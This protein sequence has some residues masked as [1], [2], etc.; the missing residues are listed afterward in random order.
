MLFMLR[1]KLRLNLLDAQG[2]IMKLRHDLEHLG[3]VVA[4]FENQPPL[5]DRIRQLEAKLASPPV[6]SLERIRALEERVCDLNAE[7]EADSKVLHDRIYAL[8]ERLMRLED[9]DAGKKISTSFADAV[10]EANPMEEP[11]AFAFARSG[12]FTSAG[13]V[14]PRA[15]HVTLE[16]PEGYHLLG[17]VRYTIS[18]VF[19]DD[20][21]KYVWISMRAEPDEALDGT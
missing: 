9:P 10:A 14:E 20:S 7:A 1:N 18:D 21:A 6:T 12:G 13:G 8:D 2:H 11:A 4:Q 3:D 17:D 5:S 16:A 15:A 19:L